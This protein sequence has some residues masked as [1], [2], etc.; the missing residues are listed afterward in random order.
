[1]PASN[2]NKMAK[3]AAWMVLFKWVERGLGLLSSL[4]LVRLLSPSDFGMMSM[5]LSFIVMAEMLAAFSFDVALI[6]NQSATVHHYNSAWTANVML[7][8]SITVLMLV[9]AAPIADF[10]RQPAVFAVVC[11]LAM[12]PLIGG[13][14]N[15]GVV[16]F[17]KDLD[18]RKEFAFQVSRKFI[19][20]FV[21]VPL[22]YWLRSY[23]ALVAGVLTSRLAGTAISY[24]AHPFR[25]R[26]SMAEV[27]SLLRFSRW[28]LLNNVVNFLKE[29]TSD[30]VV[31]RVLGPASLGLY[32]VSNEFS[33]LPTNEVG[34]PVNRA[35]L[36]GFAKMGADRAE[37]ARTYAN[38]TGLLALIAI[39]IGAGICAVAPYLVPVAL[40]PKWI[41]GIPLM[42]VLSLNSSLLVFHG[43]ICTLLIATGHPL[44]IAR[45]NGLFVAVLLAAMVALTSRFGVVGAAY[46]VATA[47]VVT[48]PVYLHLLRRH[49]GVPMRNF[50]KATFR[51]ALAAL[52]M[53]AAV[54]W[55]MPGYVAGMSTLDAGKVLAESIALGIVVYVT[56]EIALWSVVG[57][58]QGAERMVS[59]RLRSML[60]ARVGASRHADRK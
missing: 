4:I 53:I 8:G 34:A 41:G 16:A 49:A 26:P 38:V 40:G 31:G 25:P 19:A 7:G 23:W 43:T 24:W 48:T 12:G 30:F 28:L 33:G 1:M 32:S 54:R 55:R 17:R 47:C 6:H 11:T 52:V 36:P 9:V 37:V 13:L 21:T 18:F 45:T 35:L 5:A 39:P 2:Q 14:E 58:P 22:A 56:T 51:P 15:I 44:S 10:Y 59:Q 50:F 27:P 20:F 29:R 3:G 42:E 46:S 60:Q 57:W